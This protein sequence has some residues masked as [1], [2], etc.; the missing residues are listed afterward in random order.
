LAAIE[1]F[2]YTLASPNVNT[3]GAVIVG[4]TLEYLVTTVH[5]KGNLGWK[6]APIFRQAA[7]YLA[8]G[9]GA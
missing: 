6:W 7:I 9:N 8:C 5:F 3:I 2:E 4:L 1:E